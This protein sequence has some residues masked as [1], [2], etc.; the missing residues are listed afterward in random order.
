[1][2]IIVRFFVVFCYLIRSFILEESYVFMTGL[3]EGIYSTLE[4]VFYKNLDVSYIETIM[5]ND[6][7]IKNNRYLARGKCFSVYLLKSSHKSE[8]SMCLKVLDQKA[9]KSLE[10]DIWFERLRQV[11][12]LRNSCINPF[13]LSRNMEYVYIVCPYLYT[14]YQKFDTLTESGN[15]M[16]NIFTEV[17]YSLSSALGIV[18]ND[19][20]QYGFWK[21]LPF[22]IDLSDLSNC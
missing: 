9:M 3:R 14:G 10:L 22:I 4:E 16:K 8:F 17:N 11:C 2:V 15:D 21:D 1:M 5:Q 13:Y 18:L 20:P 19:V 6:K 12:N 7:F